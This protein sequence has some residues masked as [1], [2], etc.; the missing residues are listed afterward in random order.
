M[1]EIAGEVDAEPVVCEKDER[2]HRK[3]ERHAA[4]GLE[5]HQQ[6]RAC[7]EYLESRNTS[8]RHSYA[9]VV[10]NQI[11]ERE[12]RDRDKENIPQRG[13]KAHAPLRAVC[14]EEY[15]G[16]REQKDAVHSAQ[17]DGADYPQRRVVK[18]KGRPHTQRGGD[19]ARHRPLVGAHARL[20]LFFFQKLL[21]FPVKRRLI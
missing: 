7:D 11:A 17:V 20:G 21:R 15:E 1:P 16:E 19:Y 14:R 5:D 12:E 8:A 18:L 10:E 6:S 13:E 4:G 3:V 9:L 2:E